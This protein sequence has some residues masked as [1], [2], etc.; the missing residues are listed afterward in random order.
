MIQHGGGEYVGV[1]VCVCVCVC[2]SVCES[3]C[4]YMSVCGGSYH[5]VVDYLLETLPTLL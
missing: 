3:V 1:Y 4:V 5:V 2:V